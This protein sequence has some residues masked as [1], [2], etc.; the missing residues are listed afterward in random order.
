[1]GW[2]VGIDPHASS[3]RVQ[4]DEMALGKGRQSKRGQAICVSPRACCVSAA[5]G[6]G[7]TSEQRGEGCLARRPRFRCGNYGVRADIAV[8]VIAAQARVSIGGVVGVAG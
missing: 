2:A 7:T 3:K 4:S 5:D 8:Q 1:V 6:L